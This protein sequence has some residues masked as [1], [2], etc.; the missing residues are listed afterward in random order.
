MTLIDAQII[1]G[2][3]SL[4]AELVELIDERICGDLMGR[5]DADHGNERV[6]SLIIAKLAEA[7]TEG[8]MED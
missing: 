6:M 8:L 1:A 4:A 3:K 7:I 5:A 2:E